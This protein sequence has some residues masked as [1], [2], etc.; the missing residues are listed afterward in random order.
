MSRRADNR[1]TLRVARE[2]SVKER[3]NNDRRSRKAKDHDGN[4]NRR[5]KSLAREIPLKD[6][7]SSCLVNGRSENVEDR[8]CADRRGGS[9]E[10]FPRPTSILYPPVVSVGLIPLMTRAF[11]AWSSRRI[12]ER[13]R[14]RKTYR[15]SGCKAPSGSSSSRK[16][17]KKRKEG[18][19]IGTLS[20][21]RD[22]VEKLQRRED[23]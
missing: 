10:T 7:L 12:A 21:I 11:V 14:A 17:T 4:G 22:Q 2:R 18:S 6:S 19:C 9:W 13:E 16:Q 1:S 3:A 8:D 23:G 20:V 5:K 15:I